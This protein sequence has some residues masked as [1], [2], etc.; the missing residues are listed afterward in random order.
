MG[1]GT[2]LRRLVS[3][4]PRATQSAARW[5]VRYDAGWSILSPRYV[6]L[7]RSA[8]ALGSHSGSGCKLRAGGTHLLGE[9]CGARGHSG[10]SLACH[11]Q[12]FILQKLWHTAW[13]AVAT[14]IWQMIGTPGTG[15]ETTW[16]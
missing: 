1:G 9:A 7:R 2:V 13:G 14:A 3:P 11:P 12:Y 15:V 8:M 5:G 16:G 10:G 6:G 4:A